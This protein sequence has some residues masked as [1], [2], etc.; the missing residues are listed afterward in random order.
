MRILSLI[1]LLA[2]LASCTAARDDR[3]V[4][5]SIAAFHRH[6]SAGNFSAACAGE[7]GQTLRTA[8]AILGPIKTS[9]PTAEDP[10]VYKTEYQR[11]VARER[12]AWNGQLSHTIEIDFSDLAV[13]QWKEFRRHWAAGSTDAACAMTAVAGCVE[14]LNRVTAALGQPEVSQ[15]EFAGSVSRSRQKPFPKGVRLETTSR[16]ANGQE[17]QETFAWE[18]APETGFRIASFSIERKGNRLP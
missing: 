1:S 2:T 9:Q 12:F 13:G 8:F 3:A 17:A 10:L 18:I 15:E 4:A 5:D 6:Y 16:F 11:G 14:Q 7:C